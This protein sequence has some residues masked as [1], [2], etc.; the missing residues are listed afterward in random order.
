[1]VPL[2]SNAN[3]RSKAPAVLPQHLNIRPGS[4]RDQADCI[5]AVTGNGM[6]PLIR[7][8][9]Y[10]MVELTDKLAPG[11]IGIFETDRGLAIRQ[12]Y[13]VGLRSFRPELE[14]YHISTRT[15]YRI[16]GRCLGVV[17]PEDIR[18]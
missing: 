6:A 18:N 7:H 11:D 12:Y 5:F 10:V 2:T 8:N 14:E 3:Q 13:K 4:L 17:L 1:M 15:E 16:I 9:D